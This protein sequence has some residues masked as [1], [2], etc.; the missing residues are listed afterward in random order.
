[1]LEF[2]SAEIPILEGLDL[3]Q[4][5]EGTYTLLAFPLFL[6]GPKPL[7]FGLFYWMNWIDLKNENRRSSLYHTG[8]APFLDSFM[9]MEVRF[10]YNNE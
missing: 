3:S 2:L 1:M 6:K 10:I 7:R 8:T 5:E 4:V 9:K